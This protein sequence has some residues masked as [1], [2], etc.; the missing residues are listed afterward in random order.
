MILEGVLS[1]RL[2]LRKEGRGRVPAV[3]LLLSTPTI[4]EI[5]LE[6]RTPDLLAALRD[7]TFFG[8]CTF[9]QSLKTLYENN[10]ISLEEALSAADSP[11]DLK[12]EIKGI[13]RDVHR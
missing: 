2:L 8:T 5:L 11:D 9:N 7:S 10:I 1:Q 13:T 12:L 4:R 3:E 6:G